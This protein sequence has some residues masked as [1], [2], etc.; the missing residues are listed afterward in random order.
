[1]S[2][3][4]ILRESKLNQLNQLKQS[5]QYSKQLISTLYTIIKSNSNPGITINS[6]TS[7][8]STTSLIDKITTIHQLNEEIDKQ[9]NND[10]AV[11]FELLMKYKLKLHKAI[12]DCHRGMGGSMRGGKGQRS[13]SPGNI[14]SSLQSRSEVIDQELRILEYTL[15]LLN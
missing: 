13:R 15:K 3:N 12:Q 11:N 14:I 5:N 1:M 6:L 9:L 4:D 2:H 7:S 10:I 8:T